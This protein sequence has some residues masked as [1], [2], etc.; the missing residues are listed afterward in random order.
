RRPR[1][2]RRRRGP[3]S[4]RALHARARSSTRSHLVSGGLGRVL[5]R[6]L[7][8]H[9][10]TVAPAGSL[11]SRSRNRRPP[12]WESPDGLPTTRPTRETVPVL[13][14]SSL[15]FTDGVPPP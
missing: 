10:A 5:R 8:D 13:P 3:A 6:A 1:R 9:G 12:A 11:T 14:A 7:G 2:L 15:G 4:R